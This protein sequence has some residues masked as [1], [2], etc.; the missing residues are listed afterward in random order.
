M[1]NRSSK[2]NL[3]LTPPAT[4]YWDLLSMTE[5]ALN[6]AGNKL[7]PY[8]LEV[9][10]E[11]RTRDMSRRRTTLLR[12]ESLCLC[13]NFGCPETNVLASLPLSVITVMEGYTVDYDQEHRLY[14]RSHDRGRPRDWPTLSYEYRII[15]GKRNEDINQKNG[16]KKLQH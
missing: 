2:T 4:G 11:G 7:P 6:N 5:S 10:D 9:Y 3:R 8:L 14:R 1:E 12:M 16:W 13:T 15:D